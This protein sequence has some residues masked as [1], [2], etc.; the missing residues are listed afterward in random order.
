[1]PYHRIMLGVDNS[2]HSN[3]AARRA[4]A[5]ARAFDSKIVGVHVFAASMHFQ[6]FMDLEPVLP[7]EY[8]QPKRLEAMRTTHGS[9]IAEGLR[10][11]S[12]SYI[13]AARKALG[14]LPLEVKNIDGVN[15]FEL[16]KES[17]QGYDLSV[18]GARGLGLASLN[19]GAPSNAL[20]SVCERFIRLAH[21]DVLVAKDSAPPGGDIL[22]AVDGSPE[23]YAALHKALNLAKAF[24]ARIEAVTCFDPS[25]HSVVFEEIVKVLSAKN[26]ALFKFKEQEALHD[27]IINSGLAANYQGYLEQAKTMAGVKGMEIGACLLR[28]RPAIEIAKRVE[29]I[30]P[31]LLVVS[32]FGRHHTDSIDIGSTSESLVRLAPTNVLIV[33]ES[34]EAPPQP[35]AM[36]WTDE[37]E[38]RIAA[39]PEFMRPMVKR[40]VE[41][42]A[43][44]RGLTEITAEVVTAA[45]TGHGVPLPE[46]GNG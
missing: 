28:G 27:R 33:D 37:A 46:H 31:S 19:G 20:G 42:H 16:V 36:R 6:R 39:V 22:V 7:S 40:A 34:A 11:I 41:S 5:I 13:E 25:F 26:A 3:H 1:M 24:H 2:E 14:G 30:R 10:I 44:S 15:Y 45:K 12:E 17:A 38:Q 43:R 9:L 18:I 8:K 21:T 29:E 4:A 32:R 35:Q 23:C